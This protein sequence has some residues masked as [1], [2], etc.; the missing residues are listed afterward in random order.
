MQWHSRREVSFGGVSYGNKDMEFPKF[1]DLPKR[2][3][4]PFRI[5]LTGATPEELS[6]CGWEVDVGWHTSLTP[7]AYRD[8]IGHSRAEFAVAKHGYV[9][10][11]G[12]WF[13]DRS[14]CYLASGR[15]VLVQNT[16]QD[17]WLAT[18]E[19]VL[20]FRDVNEALKGVDEINANYPRHVAAARQIAERYF[21]TEQV[22]PPLL[23][24]AMD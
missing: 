9:L 23:E 7:W 18:G 20:T 8:F 4:Q 11:R 15:P 21:A 22:L 2:T 16:G 6:R 12:G 10:M 14:A 13:S 24:K 19:G 3:T 1:S 17:E 5:A